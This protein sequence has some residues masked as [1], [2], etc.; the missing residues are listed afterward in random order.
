MGGSQTESH[1]AVCIFCIVL[2]VILPKR[3]ISSE[4]CPHWHLKKGLYDVKGHATKVV[5]SCIIT[6]HTA[7]GFLGH[8]GVC[9]CVSEVEGKGTVEQ[10]QPDT[11]QRLPVTFL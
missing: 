8:I 5:C 3:S 6:A 11:H 10:P 4:M 7:C 9:V 2:N 1:S